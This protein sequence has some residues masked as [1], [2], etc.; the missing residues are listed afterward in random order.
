MAEGPT[1]NCSEETA[2]SMKK[3]ARHHVIEGNNSPNFHETDKVLVLSFYF[4][5]L[6]RQ[7]REQ[8]M[9]NH[10]MIIRVTL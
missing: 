10:L 2:E 5:Q 9:L 8:R 7:S 4:F 1:P 6:I 3:G